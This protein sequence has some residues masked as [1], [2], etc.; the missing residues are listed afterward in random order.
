[1]KLYERFN[2]SHVTL[3]HVLKCT[4][5][6]KPRCFNTSHVT[7]YRR[8]TGIMMIRSIVSIHLMLLFIHERQWRCNR[9]KRF[10]TS[11]VTLYRLENFA[12]PF[13][14]ASFNTS[15][16]TLY[17]PED[18]WSQDLDGRFNTSHVTL[19]LAYI[20]GDT[21]QFLL[22]QYI[23]C[24]S[25]SAIEVGVAAGDVFQYI[26]CYSLSRWGEERDKR[27]SVSIHL[28]LL[29]IVKGNSKYQKYD[30]FNTSH[31]TLYQS[32][33]SQRLKVHSRF[34]TSHVT[35][36]QGH[37]WGISWK[38][39]VSIH[40]MLLFIPALFKTFL[41]LLVV[42]IHLMLLFICKK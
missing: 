29:F 4:H 23:S 42:S 19:Y 26:S 21:V 10:N 34:N 3:Y 30:R 35:L 22:F 37:I 5:L 8:W 17:P 38:I 28:M 7:L 31:V 24:Y 1:M 18:W 13:P 16:V 27:S 39:L 15:H 11:H 40:L 2:T 14:F 12:T 9:Q 25:L 33:H 36:Y 32:K 41:K 6:R 20:E